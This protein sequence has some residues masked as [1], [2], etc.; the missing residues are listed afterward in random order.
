[1]NPSTDIATPATKPFA[2]LRRWLP[3]LLIAL[4]IL[5]GFH[6][7]QTRHVPSGP[8]PAF[9][10]LAVSTQP[11]A[12]MSLAQWRA[13]HPGQPVALHF[14]AEWCGICRMEEG[15]EKARPHPFHR[16]RIRRRS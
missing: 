13:A 6:G 14:W 10:A 3:N 12:T 5:V 4:A 9:T 8:A 15:N 1:M 16:R 11:G 7:W 2:R